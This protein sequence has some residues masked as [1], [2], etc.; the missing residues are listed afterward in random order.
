[1]RRTQNEERVLAIL[2]RRGK[3]MTAYEILD[4]MRAFN[5]K[6][7]PPTVYRSLT[8]LMAAGCAHRLESLN[9]FVACRRERHDMTSIM[10]ICDDCGLVEEN[11]S[12]DLMK[13]L[14][15]VVEKNGF[16]PVR[17]VIEVHGLCAACCQESAS[18]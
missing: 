8:S 17:H 5:P 15:G 13:A 11:I 3:P 12:Q 7:A 6:A 14:S 16:S 1:M 10:S 9:A 4:E 2:H 18:T